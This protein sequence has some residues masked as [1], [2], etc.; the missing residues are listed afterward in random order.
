MDA[1]K[2]FDALALVP[3]LRSAQFDDV[4]VVRKNEGFRFSGHAAVYDEEA[5]LDE[6]PG[7]GRMTEEIRRGAFGPLL[8]EVERRSQNVP[9][10]LEHDTAKVL[11]TTKSGRLKLSE[12]ARGLA[13]EADLPPTTLSRDLFSLVDAGVVTGMSVGFVTGPRST[14]NWSIER[15]SN[16]IHRL[17]T[18]FKKL[19]DVAATWDPTYP[20]AE[21]QFRSQALS[22]VDSPE[23]WQ[24]LLR[25]A[26]P[27]RQDGADDGA[28]AEGDADLTPDGA[29]ESVAAASE[30][31]VSEREH[32]SRSLAARKRELT[33]FVLT[34]GGIDHDET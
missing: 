15:R 5:L 3:N 8:E 32:R 1:D 17:I 25:G 12:D 23:S 34:T 11:A 28:E 19:L 24:Q 13:V 27:Q 31:G 14:G 10:L 16:G 18:G 30:S 20:S 2:F 9:L 6:V 33:F 4:E 26:F 21:A 22:Y 29:D 7:M